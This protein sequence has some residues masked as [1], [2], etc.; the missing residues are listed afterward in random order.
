MARIPFPTQVKYLENFGKATKIQRKYIIKLTLDPHHI[1]G[2][3]LK[4]VSRDTQIS[5]SLRQFS[6]NFS[7]IVPVGLLKKEDIGSFYA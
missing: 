4:N 2:T 7:P 3:N 1:S 6:Q 5:E